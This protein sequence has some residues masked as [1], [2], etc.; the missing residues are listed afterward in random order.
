MY[1]H[2][3]CQQILHSSAKLF[4]LSKYVFFTEVEIP[5]LPV[6]VPILDFV[7]DKDVVIVQLDTLLQLPLHVLDGLVP[8]GHAA[9]VGD[10]PLAADDDLVGDLDQQRGHADRV[11][12]V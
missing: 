11:V 1:L 10:V 5:A 8:D 3:H 2:E 4:K 12:E 9:V 7:V 6:V